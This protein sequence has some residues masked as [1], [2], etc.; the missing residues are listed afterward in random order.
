MKTTGFGMAAAML[1][2]AGAARAA[3]DWPDYLGPNANHSAAVF[4]GPMVELFADARLVWTSEPIPNGMAGDGRNAGRDGEHFI[5]GGYASPILA[6]P[7]GKALRVY[8]QYYVPSGIADES[9]IKRN[10]E[11]FR[12]KFL[13]EAD[14]VIHCFDAAT[15]RTVWRKVFPRTALNMQAFT[16]GGPSLT[17]CVGGG[18]LF[19][20]SNGGRVFAL[21]A[22]TGEKLWETK[23]ARH[24]FQEKI[25]AYCLTNKGMVAFN[26]DFKT[27]PTVSGGA[28]IFND[29]RYHK[30]M[31]GGS[32]HMYYEQPSNLVA[33]DAAGGRELWRIAGGASN[34]SNPVRW[35]SGGRELVIAGGQD[36][37]VRCVE[38]RT[39]KTLWELPAGGGRTPCVAGQYMLL[40]VG[41]S[42]GQ[43]VCYRIDE[44]GAKELWKL[45]GSYG[46]PI[47]SV[48]AAA[49]GYA[50]AETSPRGQLICVELATGKVV[51]TAPA[52]KEGHFGYFPRLMGGRIICAG[53][54]SD[55]LHMY[56]S[57]P[58]DFRLL[59]D[60]KIPNAWGYEMPILPA[61]ADGRM[62]LRTHDRLVCIDLRADAKEGKPLGQTTLLLGSEQPKRPAKPPPKPPPAPGM[63]EPSNP[64]AE[65]RADQ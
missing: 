56:T 41:D 11:Q 28:V 55:Q 14:D 32:W 7:D 62:Y 20:H 25:R 58:A 9:L 29:H 31:E 45:P 39:G 23:T 48:P 64:A 50:Y 4:A 34:N 6:E 46:C 42:P 24:D 59:D 26:R 37:K 35:I 8:L 44:K 30:T 1:A 5:S 40:R 51:A 38:P 18:R 49:G 13:V 15:G 60:A 61:L 3:G 47:F 63:G 57:D 27:S 19:F 65:L 52:A 43:H 54:D 22:A 2:A 21:N 53:A 16:K 17:C 10:G 12:A 33:L 36:G